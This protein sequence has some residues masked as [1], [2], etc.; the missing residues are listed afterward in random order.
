MT[1]TETGD[2][3]VIP[4]GTETIAHAAYDT[5]W[6]VYIEEGL[7]E[8]AGPLGY[9]TGVGPDEDFDPAAASRVL[10]AGGWETVGE[11]EPLPNTEEYPW[12]ARVVR[13]D[14]ADIAPV[15]PAA[16]DDQEEGPVPGDYR[17]PGPGIVI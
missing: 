6:H 14:P 16:D 12:R 9:C 13:R 5:D 1:N 3:P 8:G 4:I 7:P 10:A 2:R 15:A 17:P 11:W